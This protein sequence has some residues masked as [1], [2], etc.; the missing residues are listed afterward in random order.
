MADPIPASFKEAQFFAE[1]TAMAIAVVTATLA[2]HCNVMP[3]V[4]RDL[5]AALDSMREPDGAVPQHSVVQMV[6][7]EVLRVMQRAAAPATH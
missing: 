2:K 4:Q 7:K 3:A 5:A 1:G 6:L